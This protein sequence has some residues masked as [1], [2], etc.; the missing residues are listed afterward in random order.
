MSE[1]LG[2]MD[3]GSKWLLDRWLEKFSG[4]IQSMTEERPATTWTLDGEEEL[5]EGALILEQRFAG[6]PD[7]MLWIGLP[8]PLHQHLGGRVLAVAGLENSEAEEN[9]AT[10]LE[11]VEQ[12]IGGLATALSTRRGI[13]VS[14]EP[15]KQCSFFPSR[16]AVIRVTLKLANKDCPPLWIAFNPLLVS[17]TDEEAA[18]PAPVPVQEVEEEFSAPTAMPTGSRTFELLLDVALPVRISFGRTQLAVKDVL[19]LTTGSI[20]E[21]DRSVSEPVDVVV[22]DCVI[23]RGE[24]VV[25]EGNY[26]VRINSIVSRKDRLR[27]GSGALAESR[28][29]A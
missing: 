15:S 20:V 25:V 9:R 14:R 8:E 29:G 19:K 17:W 6:A 2:L 3:A 24:V 7:P 18:P 26:G 16:L 4:V 11:M 28:L 22:N 1:E 23:A 13:E 27:T 12:S 5:G 21:L 10:C